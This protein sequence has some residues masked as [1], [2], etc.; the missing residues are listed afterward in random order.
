[1]EK[2]IAIAVSLGIFVTWEASRPFF[3]FGPGHW[4]RALY[5]ALVGATNAVLANLLFAGVM[6]WMLSKVATEP[7]GLLG[8]FGMPQWARFALTLLLLDIW[9]Y[10]WHR[11]NH[12]IPF[13]WR[14]H[15]AHHTDTE[16]GATTAYRFH[17][18]EIIMSSILRI[19]LIL[20]LG[21]EP[22]GLLWYEVILTVNVVFHHSN[23]N[24]GTRVDS[25][26]RNV[27]V[28]P[29]MH[30]LHHSVKPKEFSSNYSSILSVWDRV[31]GS[32]TETDKPDEIKLGLA[33]YRD[34]RW[35]GY[36]GIMLT[37]FKGSRSIG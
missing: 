18:G 34:P 36:K 15:R 1:M 14:F 19:P 30:K 28:S 26:I 25:M 13:L 22:E 6:A 37:P 32:W 5:N 10:W 23:I 24:V 16:M 2:L 31:F 9:T 7:F 35:Q 8:L 33:I 20:A 3:A 21:L 27:I 11:F 29:V 4:F 12:T 17:P